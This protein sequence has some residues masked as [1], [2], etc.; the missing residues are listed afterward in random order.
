M[1]FAE[2]KKND[3]SLKLKLVMK[4]PESESTVQAYWSP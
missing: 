1:K 3:D 2:R 4:K